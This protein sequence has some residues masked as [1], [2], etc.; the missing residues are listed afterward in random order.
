MASKTRID[1]FDTLRM[2]VFKKKRFR[3]KKRKYYGRPMHIIERE[4]L[5]GYYVGYVEKPGELG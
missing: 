2:F 3:K 5:M 4:K 1:E